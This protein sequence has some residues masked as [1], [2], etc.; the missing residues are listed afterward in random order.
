MSKLIVCVD[1]SGSGDLMAGMSASKTNLAIR[2]IEFC[3]CK[4]CESYICASVAIA[5]SGCTTQWNG[6]RAL[7]LFQ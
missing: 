1:A 5:Q 3:Q 7:G 2:S 4:Y 6:E